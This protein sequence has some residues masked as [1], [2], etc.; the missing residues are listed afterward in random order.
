M[1]R[2][3]RMLLLSLL[4]TALG[5][6]PAMAADA[7]F[8]VWHSD[9]AAGTVAL[10]STGHENDATIH[11]ARRVA[12]VFG[13]ALE[14]DGVDDYLCA[15]GLG[16][17]PEGSA[18]A[19][20]KFNKAPD[21]QFGVVGFGAGN[22]GKNDMALL[23]FAPGNKGEPTNVLTFSIC[24]AGWQG[25]RSRVIPALGQWYLLVGTWGLSGMR[26]YVNGALAA[27]S[28][29][30]R[31]GVPAHPAVLIGAGSWGQYLAATIDEVRVYPVAIGETTVRAHYEKRDY[32]LTP[33]Q[34][35]PQDRKSRENRMR[36][37]ADF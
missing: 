3:D 16:E 4:L 23:G 1:G 34:L 13:G 2:I 32:V 12:G 28:A 14:F 7:P 33:L 35:G 31:G 19:W 15:A 36:N 24:G 10:D 9:E 21:G 20:V 26:L 11:G 37:V 18:E 30:W 6:R 8:A 5:P 27:T 17:M 22:G 25:A 29:A